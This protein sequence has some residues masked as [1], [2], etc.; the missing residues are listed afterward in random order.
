MAFNVVKRVEADLYPIRVEFE[1]T[2]NSE[3]KCP[4]AERIR[5]FPDE[6]LDEDKR[7]IS[8]IRVFHPFNSL[9]LFPVS[10]THFVTRT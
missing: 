8:T 10:F 2:T 3:L 6:I 5:R 9:S 4:R 7:T 1:A